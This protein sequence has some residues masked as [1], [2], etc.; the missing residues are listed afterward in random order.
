MQILRIGQNVLSYNGFSR[1][2]KTAKKCSKRQTIYTLNSVIP[3]NTDIVKCLTP[4]HQD[5]NTRSHDTRC[6]R[7][8]GNAS[9]YGE[10]TTVHSC[11][12]AYLSITSSF[13]HQFHHHLIF[14]HKSQFF[15]DHRVMTT[16]PWYMFASIFS[17]AFFSHF[18]AVKN[19][20]INGV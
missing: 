17:T 10:E 19:A 4:D 5:K 20:P 15:T 14:V 6:S 9:I 3:C 18:S 2:G 11:Y 16:P 1:D 7:Q 13:N 12:I 8:K